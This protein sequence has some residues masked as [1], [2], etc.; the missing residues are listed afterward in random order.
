MCI[1]DANCLIINHASVPAGPIMHLKGPN[2]LF[3]VLI[4][5]T[6]LRYCV[7][8]GFE[9]LL[10]S[11]LCRQRIALK[12]RGITGGQLLVGPAGQALTRPSLPRSY[13]ARIPFS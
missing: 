4:K 12:F 7:T 8:H 13:S 1:E 2:D 3:R 11:A 5:L 9:P 6:M 10:D